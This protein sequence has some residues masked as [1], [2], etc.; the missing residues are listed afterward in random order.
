MIETRYEKEPGHGVVT[1][2]LPEGVLELI[3]RV[4]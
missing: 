3:V 1:K 2:L 4:D